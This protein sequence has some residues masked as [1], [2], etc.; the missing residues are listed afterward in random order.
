[1]IKI[2]FVLELHEVDRCLLLGC[3]TVSDIAYIALDHLRPV[4][5]ILIAHKFNLVLFAIFRL[6]R[7]ALVK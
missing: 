2:E 5:A 4:N 6:E 3:F 1:M 7:Q